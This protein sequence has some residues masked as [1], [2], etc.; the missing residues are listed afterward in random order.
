MGYMLG[1]QFVQGRYLFVSLGLKVGMMCVLEDLSTFNASC[2]SWGH[3][4]ELSW[5]LDRLG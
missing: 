3:G 1:I 2:L 5:A 4:D